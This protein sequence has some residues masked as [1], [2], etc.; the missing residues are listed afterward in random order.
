MFLTGIWGG[1]CEIVN[2]AP[3]WLCKLP[4]KVMKHFTFA[5]AHCHI[6][7]SAAILPTGILIMVFDNH[8]PKCDVRT[9]TICAFVVDEY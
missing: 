3:C 7:T 9:L 1:G 5:L 6:S 4:Q 2:F 8:I